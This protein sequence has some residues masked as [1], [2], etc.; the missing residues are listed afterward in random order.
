MKKGIPGLS[1]FYCNDLGQ[2]FS[3]RK[4]YS[5]E[6]HQYDCKRTGQKCIYVVNNDRR[7]KYYVPKLIASAFIR[8]LQN[9]EIAVHK[10]EDITDNTP[11]NL[12]IKI[13]SYPLLEYERKAEEIPTGLRRRK[14]GYIAYICHNYKEYILCTSTTKDKAKEIYA[15]AKAEKRN[16]TFNPKD[17]EK[18]KIRKKELPVGVYKMKYGFK[19]YINHNG[20]I[21][22]LSKHV[23]IEEA[24]RLYQRAKNEVKKGTFNHKDYKQY[25]LKPVKVK[26]KL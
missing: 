17:Y 10:N 11:T 26:N 9:G 21:Y 14:D 25:H 7:R 23:T 24:S 15:R 16:G 4:G 13:G 8:E 12:K 22:L 6:L 5:I 18:Y 19:S 3:T 1:G 20:R 2:I